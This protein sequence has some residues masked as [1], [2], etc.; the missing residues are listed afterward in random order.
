MSVCVGTFCDFTWGKRGEVS[1]LEHGALDDPI[2]TAENIICEKGAML[3]RMGE[4]FFLPPFSLSSWRQSDKIE[5]TKPLN[6]PQFL[7]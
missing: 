3:S 5:G 2:L 6:F 4:A 7:I 1:E